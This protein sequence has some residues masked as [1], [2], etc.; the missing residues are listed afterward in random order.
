L[1]Q[2]KSVA[3]AV[4][5]GSNIVTQH[6]GKRERDV[7]TFL[8]ATLLAHLLR[9][10][11][12]LTTIYSTLSIAPAQFARMRE[13]LVPLM[14]QIVSLSTRTNLHTLRKIYRD[15]NEEFESLRNVG[16]LPSAA[17]ESLRPT[18]AK[19]IEQLA[20]VILQVRDAMRRINV[21]QDLLR[22]KAMQT[23]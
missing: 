12:E 1:S 22:V 9:S 13:A 16:E 10:N 20:S 15:F 6:F 21:R 8:G 17:Y 11:A 3:L 5:R 2:Q 7:K 18:H 14:L 4:A 23:H 19:R